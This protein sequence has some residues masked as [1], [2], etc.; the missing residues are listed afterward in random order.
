MSRKI[1]LYFIKISCNFNCIFTAEASN[2][3]TTVAW[4]KN[5]KKLMFFHLF[6]VNITQHDCP[7]IVKYTIHVRQTSAD[8]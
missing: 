8:V 1:V 4:L 2:R 5:K 3:Y 7:V 6:M